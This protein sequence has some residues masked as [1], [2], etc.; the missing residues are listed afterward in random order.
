MKRESMF[1]KQETDAQ[2]NPFLCKKKDSTN[3][4]LIERNDIAPVRVSL[5]AC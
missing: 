5:T 2:A 3:L 1:R 4:M